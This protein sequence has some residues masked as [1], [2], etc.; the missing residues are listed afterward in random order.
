MIQEV[1]SAEEVAKKL[2]VV[3]QCVLKGEVTGYVCL[4]R[5]SEGSWAKVTSGLIDVSNFE[6]IG[7][8]SVILHDE[9]ATA[10]SVREQVEL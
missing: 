6:I 3:R 4:V 8:M 9:I 1:P 10:G 5:T 7:A 2:E